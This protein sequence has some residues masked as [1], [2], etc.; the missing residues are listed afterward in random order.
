MK[1]VNNLYY[2][3]LYAH[4]KYYFFQKPEE[5]LTYDGECFICEGYRFT[6]HFF[7]W[8]DLTKAKNEEDAIILL[9][10][11]Y[12]EMKTKS[13]KLPKLEGVALPTAI[14]YE[15]WG[16]KLA[17]KELIVP[18]PDGNASSVRYRYHFYR[19][20]PLLKFLFTPNAVKRAILFNDRLKTRTTQTVY[21]VFEKVVNYVEE[22]TTEEETPPT[23]N[24]ITTEYLEVNK[25]FT[26]RMKCIVMVH[27]F[28]ATG[29]EYSQLNLTQYARFLHRMFSK[30]IPKDEHGREIIANSPLYKTLKTLYK[31]SPNRLKTD[32]VEVFS[33]LQPFDVGVT[34][35]PYKELLNQLNNKAMGVRK[36]N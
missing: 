17:L 29:V 11:D 7:D 24:G 20:W 2:E 22:E 27:L 12:E 19:L 5:A 30:P 34:Y 25:E 26:M 3:A 28:S 16:I 4:F 9:K 13:R 18:H 14:Y 15:F 10:R 23:S 1:L 21:D 8:F 35:T 6:E 32:F 33:A 36:R 31:A